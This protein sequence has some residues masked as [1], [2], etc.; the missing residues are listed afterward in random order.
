MA[1]VLIYTANFGRYDTVREQVAQDIDV[2]WLCITDPDTTE[3]P[4]PWAHQV[5]VPLTGH[6]NLGAKLLK[7]APPADVS[8]W[9]HAIWID[10]NMEVTAP[11]FA[12]EAIAAVHDGIAVWEHPRRDC[13][14]DEIEASAPGGKESQRDRYRNVPLREQAAAYR[15]DGF[16]ENWGLYA[17]GTIVWTRTPEARAISAAWTEQVLRWGFHDQVALPYVA[18]KL[19]VQPGVFPIPQLERRYSAQLSS[20]ERAMGVPFWL[21]NRWLRIWD[22]SRQPYL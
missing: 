7:V 9:T 14:Y 19:G 1:D 2:D 16:P 3:V 6:P 11:T 15:A 18:W 17:S 8:D 4:A 10:A 12:R 13:L 20:R 22:H 21:G 5:R